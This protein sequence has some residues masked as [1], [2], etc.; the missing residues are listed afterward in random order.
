MA[1]EVME[2]W[3]WLWGRYHVP[4]NVYLVYHQLAST[5][6]DHCLHRLNCLE[7]RR[8]HNLKKGHVIIPLKVIHHPF[9]STCRRYVAYTKFY[10]LS[11]IWPKM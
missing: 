3:T 8:G 10:I 5:F 9:D 6:H 2:L 1:A 4:Q 11:F 7:D